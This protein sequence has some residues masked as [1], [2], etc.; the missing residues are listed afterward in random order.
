[1]R[2]TFACVAPWAAAASCFIVACVDLAPLPSRGNGRGADPTEGVAPPV[3][4]VGVA[5]ELGSGPTL[6]EV[7]WTIHDASNHDATNSYSGTAE[8]GDARFIQWIAG[9]V[10]AGSDYVLSVDA[11]DTAGDPC[12]GASAPFAVVAG[13]VV[14]VT[15]GIVCTVPTQD[16]LVGDVNTGSVRLEAS[17]SP[18]NAPPVACPGIDSV[19]AN[20]ASLAVGQ[21]SQLGV[22]TTATGVVTWS[23]EGVS[24]ASAG[25][26][27]QPDQ[28]AFD[29]TFTCD[30]AGAQVAVTV[31]VDAPDDARRLCAG[32]PFTQVTV[33]INCEGS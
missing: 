15:L 10:L 16:S 21:S 22:S 6:T 11:Q 33:L 18:V 4:S 14:Q 12:S 31:S 9:G 13:G 5:L 32:Q 2:S 26:S 1:M 27:F 30:T 17:V 29:P 25:G 7:Q 8:I 20:P 23:A 28:H 24:P 19:L 3:G